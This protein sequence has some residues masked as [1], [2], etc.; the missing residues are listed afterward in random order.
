MKRCPTCG[1]TYTD[2]S[3]VFCL[4]DGATLLSSGEAT[5]DPRSLMATLRGGDDSVAAHGS[6][7][8]D[9]T[10]L[11]SAPTVEIPAGAVPTALY[12]EPRQTARATSPVVAPPAPTA[13]QPQNS[14]RLI[15][16]TALATMLLLG[17]GSVGAWLF[18]RGGDDNNTNA[19]RATNSAN[20]NAARADETNTAGVA[21]SAN[22]TTTTT[23]T[24]NAR[25]GQNQADKGG[26]WFVILG[27]FPKAEE[28]RANERVDAVRR[29][30]FDARLVDSDG[31]PNMKPGLWVVVMGPYTRNNAEEVLK[32]VRPTISD[33]YTKS[34]W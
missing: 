6:T 15:F 33:A 14:T 16:I 18:F 26:R 21:N 31:Y 2:D 10:D 5:T 3:L 25:G 8:P 23:K 34:G 32:Q 19:G 30:G 11:S 13:P 9:L 29:R 28:A 27:S 4:Q 17:V 22:S 12:Q 1:S 20:S 24:G 7:P